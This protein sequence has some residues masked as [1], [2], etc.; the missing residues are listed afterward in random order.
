MQQPE[1][2]NRWTHST[3]TR[4]LKKKSRRTQLKGNKF[5]A[6][7]FFYFLFF[8]FSQFFS[9]AAWHKRNE[10]CA[11]NS[12]QNRFSTLS[13][14][15]KSMY[16]R[17]IRASCIWPCDYRVKFAAVCMWC[18][19]S[20]TKLISMHKRWWYE[21]NEHIPVKLLG[22]IR[23]WACVR[24]YQA[25]YQVNVTV[26]RQTRKPS[27]LLIFMHCAP[28]FGVKIKSNSWRSVWKDERTRWFRHK[29]SFIRFK[30]K[31]KTNRIV[32]R[33]KNYFKNNNKNKTD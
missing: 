3:T 23:L 5:V 8:F 33:I 24:V 12:L 30:L 14:S 31:I 6:R 10:L 20:A 21:Q 1:W 16:I 11:L 7:C 2:S 4:E 13:H 25:I 9:F 29:N 19:I 27:H 22:K 32:Q 15:F 26:N 28:N 17:A 18:F